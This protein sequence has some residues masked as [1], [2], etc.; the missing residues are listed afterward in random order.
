MGDLNGIYVWDEANCSN[1]E[2]FHIEMEKLHAVSPNTYKYMMDIPQ[3]HWCM[4]AFDKH[5]KSGHTTNN[6]IEAFNSWVDKYRSMP[7]LL[8]LENIRRKMVKRIHMRFQVV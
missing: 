6:I 8:L 1:I 2:D 4:H 3:K 7:A 5:V